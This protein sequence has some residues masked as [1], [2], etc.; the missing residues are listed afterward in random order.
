M[1]NVKYD[2]IIDEIREQDS[3]LV[4]NGSRNRKTTNVYLESNGVYTHLVPI[5]LD[6][7]YKINSIIASSETIDTW[8][9]EIHGNGVL[10]PGALLNLTAEKSKTVNN[11]KIPVQKGLKISIYCNGVRVE[12]PRVI[13]ILNK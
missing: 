9:A 13:L 5:E 4:L 7:N 2:K 1:A 11:L 6:S 3:S 12:K 10:I 8:T